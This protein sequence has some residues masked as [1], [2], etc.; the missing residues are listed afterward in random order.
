MSKYFK[1]NG[2]KRTEQVVEQIKHITK[3]RINLDNW[4]ETES[5]QPL[6]KYKLV[7]ELHN[8][9]KP[10]G[11]GVFAHAERKFDETKAQ[12]ILNNHQDYIDYL[13]GIAFKLDFSIYPILD[14]KSFEN[15]NGPFVKYLEQF[16]KL[17]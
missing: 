8:R 3:H 7:A 9:L 14:V 5:N 13:N 15:R 10:Y 16:A 4:V 12:E 11:M 2:F 6:N 17:K 1:E